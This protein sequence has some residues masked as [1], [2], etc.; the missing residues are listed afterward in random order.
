MASAHHYPTDQVL[1]GM[2]SRFPNPS[3][4]YS[5]DGSI[6][7]HYFV[8]YLPANSINAHGGVDELFVEF[9][10]PPLP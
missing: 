4:G 10:V 1:T 9:S 6:I 7:H 5:I 8:D 2:S 3:K